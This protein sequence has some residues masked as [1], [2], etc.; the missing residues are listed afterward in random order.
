MYG[1]SVHFKLFPIMFA[2]P[3][4]LFIDHNKELIKKRE[5]YKAIFTNFFTRNRLT[6]TIVSASTFL[7]LAAIFYY[8]YGYEFLYQTYL[9]HITRK[10][11]RHN[12]SVY[13]SLMYYTYEMEVS[14]YLNVGLF[15]PQWLLVLAIGVFFYFDLNLTIFTQSAIFVIFNKV[16]TLQYLIWYIALVPFVLVRHPFIGHKFYYLILIILSY[17]YILGSWGMANY[18]FE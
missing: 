7:A 18:R 2:V 14:S 1:L 12:K 6:F 9:Y 15:I 17:I 16:M 5:F 10:D 3:F 8:I 13:W 4:Y 11:N